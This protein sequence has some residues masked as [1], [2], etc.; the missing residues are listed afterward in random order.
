VT[1]VWFLPEALGDV[2]EAFVGY[3]VPAGARSG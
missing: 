1:A 3:D 2:E